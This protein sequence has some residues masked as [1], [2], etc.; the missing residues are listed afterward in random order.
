MLCDALGEDERA[1]HLW[2]RFKD[3]VIA[4]LDRDHHWVLARR[5]VLDIVLQL[6]N[7]TG[8]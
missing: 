5:G 8:A 1:E 4:R 6:E 3:V 7:E 2:Q